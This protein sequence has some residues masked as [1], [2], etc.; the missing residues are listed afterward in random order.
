M[1][2]LILPLGLAAALLSPLSS[3]AQAPA[4]PL[5]L[6][7]AIE[8]AAARSPS[9][10]AARRELEAADGAIQQAGALRN[11][12]LNAS[13]EDMRRETRTTTTTV[14]FPLELGGK[15]AARVTAAE[16]A[17][18]VARAVLSN[19]QAQARATVIAAFFQVVVAQE[20]AKLTAASA[21]LARRGAEAV[22]KRV[23]DLNSGMESLEGLNRSVQELSAKQVEL[24]KAQSQIEGRIDAQLKQSESLVQKVPG[25]TAKQVA[26]TSDTLKREVQGIN[27][28]LQSQASAVQS[29]GNEVKS[30]KGAVGNVDGL[31]RD[32]EAL[33]TLQRERYLEALQKNNAAAAKERSLQYP[34]VQAAK[35]GEAPAPASQS[36][37]PVVVPT[38]KP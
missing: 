34:R 15:R 11:P 9:V 23:I 28:R 7:Q 10:S 33:V 25:E 29:L 38:A 30:L 8:L 18:D 13:I 35:P 36:A 6:D 14:D 16:R 26:A 5:S 20:R 17:R 31:K 4:G 2:Y 24:T 37:G 27:S 19:A 21:D 3:L 32:V 1:R 22:G 12:T